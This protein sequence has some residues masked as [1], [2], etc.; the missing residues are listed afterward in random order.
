MLVPQVESAMFGQLSLSKPGAFS[1]CFLSRFRTA[2]FSAKLKRNA[3][4]GMAKYLSPIPRKP[5]KDKT[6]YAIRPAPASITR[7]SIFP[8]SS[9]CALTT[10]LPITVFLAGTI[11][12]YLTAH[13]SAMVSMS[14]P[15]SSK[16]AG[17]LAYFLRRYGK[18]DENGYLFTSRHIR[19]LFTSLEKRCLSVAAEKL[20][21]SP[22]VCLSDLGK[23]GRAS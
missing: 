2:C 5:P 7:S 15:H 3:F 1:S 23:I 11:S 22:C 4:H 19:V 12:V 6:A 21:Q 10:L 16:E 20:R 9:F 8:R 14:T 13:V 17:C 18:R